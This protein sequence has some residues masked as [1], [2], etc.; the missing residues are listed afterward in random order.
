MNLKMRKSI[1]FLFALLLSAST[2]AQDEKSAAALYN[3]ALALI[4]AKDYEGGLPILESALAKATEDNNEQI[5]GLAKKNGAK[6]TANFGNAK[7]KS[8]ALDEAGELFE[9]GIT[10]APDYAGN[11]RGLAA[12]TEK[13]GNTIEAIKQYI[14]AGDKTKMGKKPEKAVKLYKKARIMVGKIYQSEE[15]AQTIEAGKAYLEMHDDAEV[16]YYVCRANTKSVAD[17]EA[18]TFADKAI[19]LSGDEVDDKY[20]VAKAKAYEKMGKNAEAIEAYKLVTGDKYKA[21]AE[22]KIKLLGS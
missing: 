7:L 21:Q 1:T 14:M 6:S 17:D 10:W 5:I 13:Q 4:K 8:G 16:A 19:A 11:Y 20:Y 12:V 18:I 2:F 9:K 15:Y 3:E 22:G